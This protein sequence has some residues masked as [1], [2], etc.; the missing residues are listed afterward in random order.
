MPIAVTD[1]QVALS[2]AV[3]SWAARSRPVT[4]ARAGEDDP[5][6]WRT[7]WPGLDQLGLF[8][9]AAPGRALTDLAVALEAAAAALVPGPLLTTALAG[10]L[11]A[12]ADDRPVGLALAAP[13]L[14]RAGDG[15]LHG[16]VPL[17]LGVTP[18]GWLLTPD[19]TGTWCRID[20]AAP[21][22]KVVELSAADFSNPLGEVRIDGAAAE[23][24]PTLTSDRVRDV[25]AT[26]AA[27]E[28]S[29]VASWCL[30]TAADYAKVREQF[31]QPIG[32][33]QAVK[34]QIGRAHV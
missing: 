2:D 34:H 27:A 12:P 16:V 24:L 31:G 33:F 21:G 11:L 14:R 25:T 8:A 18:D 6:A 32:R 30:R 3:R 19:A 22:A 17:A 20:L 10:A 7:V 5:D 23:A 9:I 13:E 15:R 29:G 28:A 26:L 1:D 4:V